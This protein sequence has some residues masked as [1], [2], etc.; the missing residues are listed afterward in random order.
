MIKSQYE[1]KFNFLCPVC[2]TRLLQE[3]ILLILFLLT[4]KWNQ[5][6]LFRYFILLLHSTL[7]LLNSIASSHKIIDKS[8]DEIE[9]SLFHG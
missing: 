9:I 1:T 8:D 6:T 3:L 5:V 4:G 7:V 2:S